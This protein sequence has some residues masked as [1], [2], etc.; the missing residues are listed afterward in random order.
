M[1]AKAKGKITKESNLG[2]MAFEYPVIAKAL[3]EDYG[4]HCVSCMAAG[5][6]TL[7]TG[8]KIHGYDDKDIVK[9]V[10]RL[11]SLIAK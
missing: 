8:A 9:M 1:K 2:Q 11:N 3:Y 5:F 4:L 6:D 7:E 10:K